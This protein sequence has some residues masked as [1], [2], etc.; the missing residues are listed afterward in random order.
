MIAG[1]NEQEAEGYRKAWRDYVRRRNFIAV[2]FI[3]FIPWGFLVL[4]FIPNETIRGI[5]L[6]AWFLMWPVGIAWYA[7]QK[8]PDVVSALHIRCGARGV[9]IAAYLEH[10]LQ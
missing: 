3:G 4:K 6:W 1:V 5:L 9:R 8:C 2:I 7:Q 10:R